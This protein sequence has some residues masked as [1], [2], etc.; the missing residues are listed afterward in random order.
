MVGAGLVAIVETV[1]ASQQ[2][3]ER[4]CDDKSGELCADPVTIDPGLG[5]RP[6]RCLRQREC[7]QEAYDVCGRKS[8]LDQPATST[9]VPEAP[10][11]DEVA[12]AVADEVLDEILMGGKRLLLDVALLESHRPQVRPI[13]GRRWLETCH[14]RSASLGTASVS[15]TAP[16][17][18]SATLEGRFGAV[19]SLPYP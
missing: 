17:L 14:I 19:C 4:Q 10:L 15:R 3:P 18:G 7:E 1:S 9:R 16:L 5:V 13:G 12:R 8:P 6:E 2:E 11:P